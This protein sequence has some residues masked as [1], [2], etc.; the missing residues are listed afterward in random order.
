[1]L[2]YAGLN[3]NPVLI[4]TRQNGIPLFPTIDGYNY[5]I[6]A[7]ETP[8]GTMLLD[9]TSNYGVPNILPIRTLNWEGRIVRKD[10]SS[11]T[12]NLYPK[13]HSKTSMNMMVNLNNQ[14]KIEGNLRTTKIN[15]D[16]ML[17]RDRY[18]AV[19]Q[20][21][22]LKEIENKYNDMEVSDFSVQND[23]DSSKPVVESFKFSL[24]SQADIINDKIYFSPLFFLK[25][26]ENPFKLEKREFPVDYG[27]ATSNRYMVN[28]DLP[29]GYIVEVIP[30]PMAMVLPDNLGVFKYNI[31]A[32]DNKIQLVV[33]SEINQPIIAPI[34]YEALK[35]YF[36]KLIEKQA[37]KIVLTKI[38]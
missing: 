16:A 1:M 5:V 29:Q 9:A 12:I 3:A 26:S 7:I 20:S 6:S 23:R 10:K 35:A 14:G 18:L 37:E 15:H 30:E 21:K 8:E 19:E 32:S 22:F 13:Q 34:Y 31:F 11:S 4:S 33:D 36:S 2:R 28:I 27:Y 25:L 38:K 24:E 17:Y